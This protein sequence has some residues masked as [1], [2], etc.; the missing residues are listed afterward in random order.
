MSATHSA[1]SIIRNLTVP[2]TS[3]DSSCRTC[4][5]ASTRCVGWHERVGERTARVRVRTGTDRVGRSLAAGRGFRSGGRLR[6]CS[7]RP[8]GDLPDGRRCSSSS[9]SSSSRCSVREQV[10]ASVTAN[11]ESS[12]R[13]FEAIAM[14]RQHEMQIAGVDAGREP[15]AQGA[16]STPIRRNRARIGD[17]RVAAICS[18]TIDRELRKSPPSPSRTRSCSSMRS[19]TRSR[20]RDASPIAGRAAGRSRLQRRQAANVYD[21]IARVGG[22]TFRVVAV[23]LRLD[24]GSTI[25]TFYVRDEPRS[26]LRRG[27]RAV[28][29]RRASSSS[30]TA[31]VIASTL[32]ARAVR[33]IRGGSRAG[34]AVDGTIALAGESH[35]YRRLVAIGDTAFYALGSIDESSR[36]AQREAMRRAMALIAV[37]RSDWRWSAAS[38]LARLL[39]EPIDRLSTS[40][41]ADDARRATSPRSCR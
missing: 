29:R 7:S 13:L 18:T 36:P 12:Q 20:R 25:G 31:C 3:G 27:T 35:A 6:A 21:G 16:R 2:A 28:R 8:V 19:R 11:L 38:A 30:A 34:S 23:P 26:R 32:P 1:C 37:A 14:R 41:A 17:D 4:R 15:D 5:R 40:L 9:C 33:G 39:T 22:S 24:D 10:R